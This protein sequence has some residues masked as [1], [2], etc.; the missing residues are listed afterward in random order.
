MNKLLICMVGLMAFLCSCGDPLLVDGGGG[1]E[2]EA[3]GVVLNSDGNPAAF[4]RVK[5]IPKDYNVHSPDS[6]HEVYLETANEDGEYNFMDVVP[7]EYNIQAQGSV[8]GQRLLLTG[9]SIKTGSNSLPDG[10][11]NT[12]GSIHLVLSP[13]F[14]KSQSYVYLPGT[15]ISAYPSE[16]NGD[17]S[18]DSIPSGVIPQL[19]LNAA[20][21]SNLLTFTNLEVMPAQTTEI[22]Y[23]SWNFSQKI[24]L[25]TGVDGANI[26]SDL[27]GFPVLIR[28]NS[29]NFD[30]SQ[31]LDNGQDIRFLKE[32]FTPL[33][34][35]IERWDN[36]NNMAEIWVSVDTIYGENISQAILM[37]W[38]NE[39]ASSIG[40]GSLVFDTA[41]GFQGVW[42][43]KESANELA[44]DATANNFHGTSYNMANTQLLEGK[45]GGARS[46]NGS[47]SYIEMENTASGKINFAE[48]GNFTLSSWAYLDSLDGLAHGI[49][50][51]GYYQY[52]LRFSYFPSG[53]PVWEF[54]NFTNANNWEVI[55][56]PASNGQWVYLTGVKKGSSQYF[57]FNGVLVDS[58][59]TTY[60]NPYVRDTSKNLTIGRFMEDIDFPMPDGYS[61]F[62]G[63]I[64]EVRV[65]DRIRSADWIRLNFI[66]QSNED[67]FI[68]FE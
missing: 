23:P 22:T 24:I 13:D 37:F 25:N 10:K 6:S 40:D 47:S 18:L 15:D 50:S 56:T 5:L 9:L 42:H 36:V 45:V 65:S 66:N 27:L 52:F 57:Y 8:S 1:S 14:P 2:V 68:T 7:G 17:F 55:I 43:L 11:L 29:N 16:N 54:V 34:F 53:D 35:E 31:A 38:G 33:A 20:S 32:D 26:S 58:V 51:K 48:D 30:F 44:E 49:V 61:F 67:V 3:T 21:D 59:T 4:A 63:K 39:E 12:P 19:K 46:F 41:N 28:L 60:P 64:D 62:Q